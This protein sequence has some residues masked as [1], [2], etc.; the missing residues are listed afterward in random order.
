MVSAKIQISGYAV[1]LCIALMLSPAHAKETRVMQ[2][3]D[4]MYTMVYRNWVDSNTTF[5]VTKDGVIVIDTRTAPSEAKEVLGEI[6]KRTD[7]PIKFSINTSFHGGHSF[8]NPVF[9]ES[10]HIVA[11]RNVF[12]ILAKISVPELL[13]MIENSKKDGL[14]K[15]S[16][17]LPNLLYEKKMDMFV[18]GH[19]LELIHFGPGRTNGDT[20][21][22]LPELRMIVAGDIVVNKQIPFL[23]HGHIESWIQVLIE[24]E[25]LN[26][27]RVIPGHGD[28]GGKPILLQTKHY[29]YA[30][31]NQVLKQ[32]KAGKTLEETLK[33]VRPI[34]QNR[35]KDWA[36]Q[37][38]IDGNI[39]KA[40]AEYFSKK[41]A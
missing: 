8:D 29:L 17:T 5:L 7:L 36:R 26:I 34:I 22:Y 14:E 4:D 21:V 12:K 30:L 24:I 38:R 18:G 37:D 20:V 11:H 31:R 28:V 33:A 15:A 32:I 1:F 6:R 40:Y 10:E 3:F 25:K 13:I 23:G 41:R 2:V 9:Q 16:I 35:Y 27:E 39:K 19:H